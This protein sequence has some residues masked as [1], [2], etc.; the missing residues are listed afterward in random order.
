MRACL[1]GW[2]TGLVL[3]LV[4]LPASARTVTL[5]LERNGHPLTLS[6]DYRP[7]ETGRPA[8]LIL[9]GF[10]TTNRFST[11]RAMSETAEE[12]GLTVLAPNL[13]YCYTHRR[14][15]LQC[16]SLHRH[17]LQGDLQ[18][19]DHW[20]DWLKKQ[21]HRQVILVGHSSGSTL[22]LAWTASRTQTPVHGLIL[23]SLFPLS[24]GRLGTRSEEISL[25]RSLLKSG[26]PLPK[27]WHFLYCRGNY[28]ATPESFLSYVEALDRAHILQW[29]KSVSQRLPVEIIM[30]GAD[31]R[32]AKAG[33][34]LLDAYRQQGAR[35]IVIEGASHFFDGEHEFELQ[36][37]LDRLLN[38]L[39]K[40]HQ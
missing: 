4:L 15:P 30:G 37:H 14:A 17:T 23:T 26:N 3:C 9:H 8:V 1:P 11:V 22:L 28:L 21:G 6:A 25:A 13:S 10:L 12:R 31:R 32:Y 2:L 29:L 34:D 39:E 35:V 40:E 20:I 7:G 36:D 24:G 19:L 5:T 27:K 38:E 16:T 18:E 33:R